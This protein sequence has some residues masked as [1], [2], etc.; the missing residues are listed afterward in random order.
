VYWKGGGGGG[1]GLVGLGLGVGGG[2]F[3]MS[4][5]PSERYGDT[6]FSP[7]MVELLDFIFKQGLMDIPCRRF[8]NMVK[9]KR[10]S[11]LV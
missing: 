11:L 7:T 2:G 4:C 1:G 9:Q 5:F 8:F 3:N 6:H 10:S